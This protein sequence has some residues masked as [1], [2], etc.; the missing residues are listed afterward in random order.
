M[1]RAIGPGS[2]NLVLLR[3]CHQPNQDRKFAA[4]VRSVPGR[5]PRYDWRSHV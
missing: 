2:V 5:R 1:P 3:Q 4:L